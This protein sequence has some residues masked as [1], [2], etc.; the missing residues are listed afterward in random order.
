M[1]GLNVKKQDGD[2]LQTPTPSPGRAPA[3]VTAEIEGTAHFPARLG[4]SMVLLL[5]ARR[6]HS[7]HQHS[8]SP[9]IVKRNKFFWRLER[10]ASFTLAIIFFR[11]MIP[12]FLA[13]AVGHF[14]PVLFGPQ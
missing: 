8:T 11:R 2:G 12:L 14:H 6:G 3:S 4:S 10:R 7:L 9:L 13:K 5:G 1:N